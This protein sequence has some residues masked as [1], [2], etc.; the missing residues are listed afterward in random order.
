[1]VNEEDANRFRSRALI[2]AKKKGFIQDSEDLAHDLFVDW[3]SRDAKGQTVNHAIIDAIRRVAGR[4]TS[5]EF[6]ARANVA[7]RDRQVSLD[8]LEN[9]AGK[10]SN[11]DLAL[12]YQ[13]VVKQLKQPER[14]IF[15]LCHTWGMK[16][17]EIAE[18]FGVSE[19]KMSQELRAI[20]RKVRTLM[21]VS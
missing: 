6:E 5:P 8:L 21:Q 1:M 7:F 10:V 19:A 16:Q 14:V 13:A 9:R 20:E 2:S 3:C 11:L 18:I 12:D 17:R 15:V 4:S